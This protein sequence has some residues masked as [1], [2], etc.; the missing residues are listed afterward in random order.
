MSPE[1]SVIIPNF[2]H[3]RFLDERIRSVLD[4]TF[5]D[6]E[7]VILDDCSADDSLKVIERY[8]DNPKVSIIAVNEKNS[9]LPC[10]QWRKGIELAKGELIWIAESDDS[11]SADFLAVNV[12]SFKEDPECVISFSRS[13]KVDSSGNSLG[14]C[15]E[16][17][18]LKK[19]LMMD[20]KEVLRKYLWR[21][22]IVVNASGCV[23]RKD[24]ALSVPDAY[25]RMRGNGDWLLW[26]Q[27]AEIGKVAFHSEMRNRFRQHSSGTTK[28]L[29]T[30]AEPILEM[31]DIQD[32]LYN[33]GYSSRL[34]RWDCRRTLY[35]KSR[36]VI[37]LP[38]EKRIALADRCK[39]NSV[40]KALGWFRHMKRLAGSK[41]RAS[42]A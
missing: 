6:F 3:A 13:V 24:A 42:R 33:K 23:F 11:C 9:G 25:T 38:D 26:I 4:Q 10:S 8:R 21:R 37:D 1:V 27:L 39:A 2:N 28:S 16:Q 34:K 30:R 29:V 35:Y 20:G 40:A 15:V 17:K 22:N 31:L 12:S 14:E 18:P 19:D 32:Y 7:V 5:P 36:F 41:I